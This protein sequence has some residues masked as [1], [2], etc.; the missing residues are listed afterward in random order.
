M[1]DTA[2]T[3]LGPFFDRHDQRTRLT[4]VAALSASLVLSAVIC[5][6]LVLSPGGIFPRLVP[7]I[8]AFGVCFGP[9]F[10]LGWWA[11]TEWMSGRRRRSAPPGGG[12]PA[13]PIDARDGVRVANGGFAFHLGV[14]VSVVLQ[15]AVMALTAFGYPTGDMVPRATCVV[16]GLATIYLGNLWPRMPVARTPERTAAKLMKAHRVGGWVMVTCG[17]L[18]LALG[19]FLPLVEPHPWW[20]ARP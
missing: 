1:T 7:P 18:V 6:H 11:Y 14:N 20:I 16:I 19:L 15:Q 17:L 9:V 4:S 5:A 12:H 2:M 8:W 10:I 3:D 13:G